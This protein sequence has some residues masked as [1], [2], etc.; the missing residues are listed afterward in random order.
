MESKREYKPSRG[1]T[2][3]FNADISE[4]TYDIL[5]W[6][7]WKEKTPLYKLVEEPVEKAW[8]SASAHAVNGQNDD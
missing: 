3:A 6:I 4:R 8:G 2:R 5:Q 1:V 7:K